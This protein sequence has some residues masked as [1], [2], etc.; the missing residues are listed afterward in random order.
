[1]A[2]SRLAVW[3]HSKVKR[4]IKRGELRR[5]TTCAMCGCKPKPMRNGRSALIQHHHDY[6][7]PLHV[8]TLCRRCHLKVH[9]A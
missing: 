8:V 5:S 7:K 1:M 3:A 6:H 9:N 2:K 4:A